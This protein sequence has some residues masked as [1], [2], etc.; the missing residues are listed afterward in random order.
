MKALLAAAALSAALPASAQ[1]ALFLVRHAEKVDNSK[2]AA[3]SDA[4]L[5]RAKRLA[6]LL[7]DVGISAIFTSEYQRTQQT[8]QP[9]ADALKLVPQIHAAGD[10]A[11]LM[12]LLKSQRGRTLVVGHVNTVPEIAAAYDVKLTIDDADFE[13]LY[14]LLPQTKALIRLHQPSG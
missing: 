2:D 6:A 5:A 12:A 14:L 13:G 9:L 10:T 8:A 3:L 1:E 4:G 11:G 7:R